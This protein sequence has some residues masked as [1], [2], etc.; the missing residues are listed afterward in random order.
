MILDPL[1]TNLS[2]VLALVLPPLNKIES[3]NV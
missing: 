1:D 3:K 2:L